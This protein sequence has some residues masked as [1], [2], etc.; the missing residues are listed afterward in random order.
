MMHSFQEK[1]KN[2]SVL[3]LRKRL[4]LSF[5][6]TNTSCRICRKSIGACDAEKQS[7]FYYE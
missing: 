3:V 4:A 6:G 1:H 7:Y 5:L 2:S